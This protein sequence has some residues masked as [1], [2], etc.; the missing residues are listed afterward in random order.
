MPCVQFKFRGRGEFTCIL[1]R[2]C[3]KGPRRRSTSTTSLLS[4]PSSS[5]WTR[6]SAAQAQTWGE[7]RA[8]RACA[9]ALA[10]LACL[11]RPLRGGAQRG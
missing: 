1:H 7:E 9:A 4:T 10:R 11:L 6:S 5:A 2:C 8:L 3:V